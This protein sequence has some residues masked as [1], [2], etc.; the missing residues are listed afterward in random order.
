M[1][2]T[3]NKTPEVHGYSIWLIPEQEISALLS[4]S[5][6]E[7]ATHFQADSFQPHI[8]LLGQLAGELDS[9]L[10]QFEKLGTPD[11]PIVLQAESIESEA[12][13]FRALVYQILSNPGL[14]AF[15]Q[16][17]REKFK[18][19]S[20]T[21]FYPHLSLLYSR[22][23]EAQKVSVLSKM[24]LPER[25]SISIESLALV[26]THGPVRDWETLATLDF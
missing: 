16:K 20:D 8:T 21:P 24:Q 26:K 1:L 19:E 3:A 9:I 25:L 5:I 15:N 13:Y 18:R 14:E 2:T 12:F 22:A 6:Q 7:L 11:A 23:S 17:V 4:E 10:P